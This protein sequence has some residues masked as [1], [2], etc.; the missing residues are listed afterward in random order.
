[1][2]ILNIGPAVKA[3]ENALTKA[4]HVAHAGKASML[5]RGVRI[6]QTGEP[7]VPELTVATKNLTK[8]LDGVSAVAARGARN[9]ALF[10]AGG[11]VVSGGMIGAGLLLDND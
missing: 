10:S 4:E 7:A 11:A 5:V 6:A 3:F 1:M 8:A 9:L 2:G